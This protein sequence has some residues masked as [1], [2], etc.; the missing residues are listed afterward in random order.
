MRG[1]IAAIQARAARSK[2]RTS[3]CRQ[4]K[5]QIRLASMGAGKEELELAWL[6]KSADLILALLRKYDSMKS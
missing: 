5:L 3:L 1:C 4:R 6:R 2:S